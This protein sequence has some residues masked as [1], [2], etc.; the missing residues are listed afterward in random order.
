MK[1]VFIV[2]PID[3]DIT[4]LTKE[5][6]R[7]C[8]SPHTF[9]LVISHAYVGQDYS[10]QKNVGKIS[11]EQIDSVSFTKLAHE[12]STSSSCGFCMRMNE[13]NRNMEIYGM[14]FMT[15]GENKTCL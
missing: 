9:F 10:V 8:S 3:V 6:H 15:P 7:L 14:D 13:I 1:P 2:S 4:A 5:L 12:T 11:L